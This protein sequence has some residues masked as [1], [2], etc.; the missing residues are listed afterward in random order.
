MLKLIAFLQS[1]IAAHEDEDRGAT[2]VEYGLMVFLIA[3]AAL[4]AVTLLGGRISDLFDEIRE[5]LGG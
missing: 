5:G 1:W 3:V 4:T 2:M